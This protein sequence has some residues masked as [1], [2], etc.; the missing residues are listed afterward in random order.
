[1][2]RGRPVVTSKPVGWA[3]TALLAASSVAGMPAWAAGNNPSAAPVSSSGGQAGAPVTLD[4]AN[5]DI[6]AVARTLATITGRNVVVDP[7]VKGTMTLQSTN[8]VTPA[9][10]LRLFSAQLR[11]QGYALVDS[12]GIYVV[13]PE[14]DAKL[15]AASVSAGPVRAIKGG[16]QIQTQIFR[17]TH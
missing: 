12:E 13:V 4:F 3:I 8:P 7:R 11:A 15:Q 2:F 17:L 9:E 14:A 6:D 10:A 1:M 5:A 16:G